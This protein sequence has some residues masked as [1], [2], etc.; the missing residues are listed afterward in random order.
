MFRMRNLLTDSTKARR[1]RSNILNIHITI[2]TWVVEFIGFFGIVLGSVI[3][4][5]GNAI[6]TFSLQSFSMFLYFVILPY[7]FL[8]NE[9]AHLK[10][11]IVDNY[12]YIKFINMFNF[13][14]KKE[15]EQFWMKKIP[16]GY[17]KISKCT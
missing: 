17:S 8:I 3:L 2:L 14:Y 10:L 4:G 12:W 6:V 9:T 1:H 16:N 11:V 7:I 13:Q 15:K 5:H